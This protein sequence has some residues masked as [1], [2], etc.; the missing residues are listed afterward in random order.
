MKKYLL[1]LLVALTSLL[2]FASPETEARLQ[3]CKA[4]AYTALDVVAAKQQG[5]TK[6]QFE[7]ALAELLAELK[8]QLPDNELG[9]IVH[10]LREAFASTG[11]P[12]ATAQRIFDSCVQSKR[13]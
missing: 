11:T 1:G 9:E 4:T 3:F 12:Q 7:T 13:T 6:G 8:G 5:M 10:F 2:A